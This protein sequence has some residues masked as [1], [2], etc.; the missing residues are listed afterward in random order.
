MWTDGLRRCLAVIILLATV[1]CGED[2]GFPLQDARSPSDS[3]LLDRITRS[4]D[5]ADVH[6]VRLVQ[7]G[8][9]YAFEP[10]AIDL[11][12]GD[13]V[14]FVMV[15]SQ[16]ESVAFDPASAAPEVAAFIRQNSLQL[17][18]LLTDAGQAYD[19]SFRDAPAGHYPFVSIPHL[20]HGMRGEVIVSIPE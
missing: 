16:P 11:A 13:V 17:G 2:L 3:E 7:R 14:R 1:A 12:P 5:G 8:D 4:V 15:G 9:Q 10:S 6:L 20:P 18:V 19:V